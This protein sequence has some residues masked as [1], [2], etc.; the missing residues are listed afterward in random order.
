[1][2]PTNVLIEKF[3]ANWRIF[4]SEIQEVTMLAKAFCNLAEETGLTP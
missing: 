1:M 2:C 4:D 3:L